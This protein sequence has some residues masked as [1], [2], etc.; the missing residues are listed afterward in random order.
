M[1]KQRLLLAIRFLK[2]LVHKAVE[3]LSI[4]AFLLVVVGYLQWATLDKSDQTLKAA[5]RPWIEFEVPRT[6]AFAWGGSEFFGPATFSL[7]N[8][9]HSPA[10]NVR[11]FSKTLLLWDEETARE[12]QRRIC[13][14]FDR[15]KEKELG[16]G[17]TVFPNRSVEHVMLFEMLPDEI[18]RFRVTPPGFPRPLVVGCFSYFYGA[19]HSAHH[20]GFIYMIRPIPAS[21]PFAFP[22]VDKELS[23]SEYELIPYLSSSIT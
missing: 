11:G 23:P 3:P 9:G 17:H 18:A 13:D 7:T 4:F 12:T 19:D 6:G 15:A 20:T 22:K 2:P 14:T 1:Q 8:S 21:E 16:Y 5:Q 10:L